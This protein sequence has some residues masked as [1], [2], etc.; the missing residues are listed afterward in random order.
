VQG[1]GDSAKWK[2]KAGEGAPAREDLAAQPAAWPASCPRPPA[3]LGGHVAGQGVGVAGDGAD[4]DAAGG[5]G[6]VVGGRLL[7]VLQQQVHQ[8]EVAQVVGAAPGEGAEARG[9]EGRERSWQGVCGV[10]WGGGAGA[11]VVCV[12]GGVLGTDWRTQGL[13]SRE[14]QQSGGGALSVT[15]GSFIALTPRTARIRRR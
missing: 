4:D 9:E 2:T 12:W 14:G 7:Q 1:K 3:C 6:G 15:A 13:G 10:C 8:Q 5:A 11:A